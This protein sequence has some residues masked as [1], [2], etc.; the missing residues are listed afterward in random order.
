MELISAASRAH[1]GASAQAEVRS[2][3]RETDSALAAESWLAFAQRQEA[4]G[5]IESA[6]EVYAALQ[7]TPDVS[8]V[9]NATWISRRAQERLRVLAGG[10][11][12]GDRF[13]FLAR[14]FAAQAA[15]PAMIAGMG[16]AATVSSLV[17]LGTLS[18][19]LASPAS[20]VFSR[21]VGARILAASAAFAP[22]VGA[23]WA[24]SRTMSAALG[25]EQTWDLGSVSREWASLALGLGLLKFSGWL[26]RGLFDRVHGIGG[27]STQGLSALT[28]ASRPWVEQLGIFGGIS[29]AH[30][31]E[32]RL[33][34][35]PLG[36]SESFWSDS[37]A[38]LLQF[39][40]GGRL[41]AQ[42]LGPR[43][44][45]WQQALVLRTQVL[46]ASTPRMILSQPFE[47]GPAWAIAGI[48]RIEGTTPLLG[49][50]HSER[51]RPGVLMMAN[52]VDSLGLVGNSGPVSSERP[53]SNG[54][55][56]LLQR[57]LVTRVAIERR[58][59][60]SDPEYFT[61]ER[62][63]SL[64]SR[65]R[66]GFF[67][68]SEHARLQHAVRR[69]LN[70][71]GLSSYALDDPL[72]RE[73]NAQVWL[74][75]RVDAVFSANF[76]TT[77]REIEA[78]RV[79]LAGMRF[80]DGSRF[81]PS[82]FQRSEGISQELG[83]DFYFL[84]DA[85]RPTGSF[86]E[87][88]AL[89]EVHRAALAGALHVVT[90]SHG[91]HGLAVALAA[92]KLGLRST[93]VVP[94]TTPR[95]KIQRLQGLGATVV[96]TGEQPWRGYEEARDW[97][98]RYTFERNL[99]L[100]SSFDIEGVMRY[101]HGFEDVIPGQGVAGFE[102]LEAIQALSPAQ[103]ERLSHASFL[104]PTGGGGLTAGVGTVLRRHLPHARVIAVASEEAPALHFSLME[105]RRSEVFLNEKGLCD[106]GI[107]LTIPGAKPFQLLQELLHG[108][109]TVSDFHVAEAMRR[110]YRHEGLAVEGGAAT[111]LAAVL[112]GRLR[113]LDVDPKRPLVS[114]LTGGNID[115]SRHAEVVSLG[116][117]LE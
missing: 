44:A 39:H 20:N 6:A 101:V 3:S 46:S 62:L 97:A 71:K 28:R 58:I 38:T 10:G 35:R 32:P 9:G 88:G 53:A 16:A 26:S 116:K 77:L 4:A 105:G 80:G 70:E 106:S 92:Q 30:Y 42:V 11:R 95:V 79:A 5:E 66:R 14:R 111:G 49:S 33:G 34:L 57:L 23:F 59:E 50:R 19:L 72:V 78:A 52:A 15:D 22:E 112:S 56:K 98:L 82:R 81:E 2:I 61:P 89:I 13:E 91:N 65:L 48:S 86:K 31:L 104:L 17:R 51:M 114:V 1:L 41:S 96:T 36:S 64:L 103:R 40:V 27:T 90:A 18:R 85:T 93:I 63:A 24:A 37:L 29:L 94:D 68:R 43:Y 107:G 117:I 115:P 7:S 8:E 84:N 99:Y 76:E 102:M 83:T 113:N 54:H 55:S 12:M 75:P 100:Q 67:T 45:A 74:N 109:L 108:S 47:L 60:A 73:R 21:G 69:Y 87:R 25:R 110:I